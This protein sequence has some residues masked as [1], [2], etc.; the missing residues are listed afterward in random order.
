MNSCGDESFKT[1]PMMSENAVLNDDNEDCLQE[2]SLIAL[3][4]VSQEP[5]GIEE[6]VIVQPAEEVIEDAE[7]TGT[8]L[9]GSGEILVPMPR[10]SAVKDIHSNSGKRR[11]VKKNK[12]MDVDKK[13]AKK[14]EQKQVQIKTLEGEFS[15]TMWASGKN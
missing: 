13:A 2:Q 6:G 10:N 14:W 4:Q 3:H 5:P 1:N 9:I 7:I 11:K 12:K 15:V 8:G